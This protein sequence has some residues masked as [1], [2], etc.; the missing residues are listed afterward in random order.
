VKKIFILLFIFCGS[1]LL[2]AQDI[3]FTQFYLAPLVLNP[4]LSGAQHDVRGV[5]N[6]KSQWNSVAQPYTTANFSY[7]QRFGQKT[8]AVL[9]G[10]GVSVG[11]DKSGNPYIK[12]FNA[13]LSYAPQIKVSQRARLGVGVYVGMIQR[14][15]SYEGLKWA[16]QYDGMQYNS[17]LATKE[18]EGRLSLMGADVGTGIHYEYAKTERYM[19]GNDHRK[20]SAG[21]SAFH[22]NR[23]AYSF[24]NNSEKLYMKVG[25]YMNG[26]IGMGNSDL[27][28]VP[29]V[30]YYM[31]GT[32]KELLVGN[33]FQLKLL[34]DSKYTGFVQ[35]A[36]AAIGMY[37]RG[38]DAAIAMALLKVKT[39]A[40]GISYDFNISSLKSASKGRGGFELSLRY[41][42]PAN[43]LYKAKPSIE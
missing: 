39:Y 17:A 10:V 40:I 41:T 8:D 2:N 33:L 22:L 34:D 36:F 23:P 26:E 7:D 9:H 11:Q 24:Y 3:H 18:P 15:V 14:S 16:N 31:Q 13:G 37:Y 43:Y 25:G 32:A 5:L 20:F 12:T 35:G 19:T 38:K 29:G 21:I 42:N 4:A 6:Y 1:V 27:S 28:L 30:Y